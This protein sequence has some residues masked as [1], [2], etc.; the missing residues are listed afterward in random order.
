MIVF[1]DWEQDGIADHVGIVEGCRNGT[2]YTIEGNA[3]SLDCV[4]LKEYSLSSSYI[5]GYGVPNYKT[6][7]TVAIDLTNKSNPGEYVVTPASLA[8]R[9]G[10]GTSNTIVGYLYYGTKVQVYETATASNGGLWGK[11]STGWIYMGYTK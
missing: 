11:I 6:G 9:S 10:P 1:F 4:A 8:L 2:V 3:G 5:V 7:T